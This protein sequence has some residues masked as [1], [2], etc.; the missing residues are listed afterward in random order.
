LVDS[1]GVILFVSVITILALFLDDIRIAGAAKGSDDAFTVITVII[2]LFFVL[3]LICNSLCKPGYFV[4]P[5]CSFFFWIDLLS[6]T[7]MIIFDLP[8]VWEAI[9][10]G[11]T[12]S[13]SG[14]GDDLSAL[15]AA[16]TVGKIARILRL[17]KVIR[18]AKLFEAFTNQKDKNAK[19]KQEFKESKVAAHLSE[20]TTRKVV[21]MVLLMLIMVPAIMELGQQD[22]D[23]MVSSLK[24]LHDAASNPAT[25]ET[26]WN[27]SVIW[28]EEFY[29]QT[30]RTP[31]LKFIIKGDF[32][33]LLTGNGNCCKDGFDCGFD[34]TICCDASSTEL[35]EYTHS[36]IANFETD[37]RRTE[38]LY[39]TY[40]KEGQSEA[41]ASIGIWSNKE[42]AELLGIYNICLTIMVIGVLSVAAYLFNKTTEELVIRPIER[43]LHTIN[44]LKEKPLEQAADH[45]EEDHSSETGM[46]ERTLK[47]LTGLLQVG[48]GEAGSRMIA[49]CMNTTSGDLNPLVDG[50]KMLAIFGFCD[51]RRFTDATECLKEEVMM[52]VNEIAMIVHG[53]TKKCNGNPNKNVGDAFLLVWRLPEEMTE[54]HLAEVSEGKNPSGY[55]DKVEITAD[56]SLISFIRIYL[57]VRA[58]EKLKKYKTH[59]GIIKTFGDSFR[60]G[61]GFGLH[62]GWAIEGPIGSRFKIDA[63]YL[64]PHVNMSETVQDF[65]KVYNV[66]LLLSG[67]FVCLLSEKVKSH[68]RRI[69]RIMTAGC[70]VPMDVYTFDVSETDMHNLIDATQNTSADPFSSGAAYVAPDPDKDYQSV[71]DQ[72]FSV[73]QASFPD[74]FYEYFKQAI[75]FYVEGDWQK[76]S[77]H[78]HN[79]LELR[80]D[81][82]PTATLMA[83]M[84][85]HKF[86]APSDWAGYRDI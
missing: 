60:V 15:K 69:D 12:G 80:K 2:L 58:S 78:F 21:V 56:K 47:Q 52:Y 46:L 73:L 25:T 66:P 84:E 32:P 61:L 51:I 86:Q 24:E 7:T 76:S 1:T 65:C 43:M 35:C 18:I 19:K 34:K 31:S 79:A 39:W 57:E 50:T 41:D 11:S 77:L 42:D 82:P 13:S 68:C 81:D 45:G 4:I 55:K 70:L 72:N 63:S 64:S 26:L 85:S 40:A 54:E 37:L 16:P 75:D 53:E 30:T 71:R 36:F 29:Q 59:P 9:L 67:E 6:I 74:K 3:E 27:S 23:T 33:F 62:V 14:G 10:A 17:M 83:F 49:K 28:T 8:F 44:Q 48:F 20:Q 22:D 38:M 5:Y